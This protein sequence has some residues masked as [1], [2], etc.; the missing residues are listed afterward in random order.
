MLGIGLGS[1][2]SELS[3]DAD[4]DADANATKSGGDETREWNDLNERLVDNGFDVLD[5][6]AA[7]SPHY[8]RNLVHHILDRYVQ[9]GRAIEDMGTR[10]ASPLKA[11]GSGM[12]GG[13]FGADKAELK[14]VEEQLAAA[15]GRIREMEVNHV[16]MCVF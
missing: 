8:V 1:S 9:R 13:G 6:Q 14:R 5:P 10:A 11:S 7:Q 2:G 3:A 16:Y 12:E 15:R 4:A